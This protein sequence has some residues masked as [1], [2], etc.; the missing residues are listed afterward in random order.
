M[1][2][3][4]E[5]I[6]RAERVLYLTQWRVWEEAVLDR[7]ALTRGLASAPLLPTSDVIYLVTYDGQHLGH[8]RRGGPRT[9]DECWVAVPLM[10]VPLAGYHHSA[11]AA[12][13]AL[14]RAC[15]RA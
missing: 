15:G 5:V 12:A 10:Q 7:L 14:A 4:D 11:E 2:V 13:R 6:R 8:V 3:D 9:R 1:N